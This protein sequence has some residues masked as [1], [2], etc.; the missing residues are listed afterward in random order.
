M[1]RFQ[2]SLFLAFRLK[3]NSFQNS[4][5]SNLCIFISVF[6]RLGFYGGAMWTQG[7]NGKV[8]L[9]FHMKTEQYERG[10]VCTPKGL[11]SLHPPPWCLLVHNA[12]SY[13]A[14]VKPDHTYLRKYAILYFLRIFWHFAAEVSKTFLNHF[15][16]M[17]SATFSI[18]ARRLQSSSDGYLSC[19]I[20]WYIKFYF[21]RL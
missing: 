1:K 13:K 15:G 11:E 17:W 5:F 9:R 21:I 7:K 18:F 8:L 10:Q 12:L 3:P 14:F 20:H 6:E 16:Y 4:P 2:M 19:N